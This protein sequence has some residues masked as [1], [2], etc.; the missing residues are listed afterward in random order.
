MRELRRYLTHR[1]VDMSGCVEK[2]DLLALAMQ[3][4]DTPAAE[5]AGAGAGAGAAGAAGGEVGGAAAAVEA[6][7][8]PEPEP[9]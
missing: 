3:T 5:G 4:L 6:M 9:A 1:G 7:Q 2:A 8:E